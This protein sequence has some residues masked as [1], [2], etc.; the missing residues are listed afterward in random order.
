M[1]SGIIVGA[2]AFEGN[3]YDGHILEPQLQQV[4]DMLGSL[5]RTALVDRGYKGAREV[6]GVEIR[7]PESGK[8]KS[9]Y[10]KTKD[11]KRFRRR[12]AIEPII[13]HLKS[14]YRMIRNYL[15]EG[16]EGDKVNTLMAAVAFNFIKRLKGIWA[17]ILFVFNQI[18]EIFMPQYL[19]LV[20][21]PKKVSS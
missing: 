21:L 13:G 8:G 2:L 9:P 20:V 15:K 18:R 7:R 19:Q 10:E 3:P 14:D 4:E 1:R 5:P 17:E 11:R 12:A 6:L 16:T